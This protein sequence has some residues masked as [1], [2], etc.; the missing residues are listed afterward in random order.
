MP[1]QG[2]HGTRSQQHFHRWPQEGDLPA[3]GTA[4]GRDPECAVCSRHTEFAF[5]AGS[6]SQETN[7]VRDS[8]RLVP[9]ES[10]W[11][12]RVLDCTCAFFKI[13]EPVAKPYA[14]NLPHSIPFYLPS[15]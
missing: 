9:G 15:P 8:R 2:S 10:R 5:K 12:P 4:R 13:S 7:W 6:T 1:T 3:E 11:G 14:K